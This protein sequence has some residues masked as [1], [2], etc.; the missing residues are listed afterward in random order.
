LTI[1]DLPLEFRPRKTAPTVVLL[2]VIALEVAFA[3]RFVLV[4]HLTARTMAST[5]LAFAL[6]FL[7]L[8]GACVW[9]IIR[10]QTRTDRLR[11][12]ETGVVADLNGVERR[13]AWGEMARLHIVKM[14]ARSGLQLVA[15]ERQ[16]EIDFDARASVIWPRFGPSTPQFLGLLRAGRARW[17]AP[18]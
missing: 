15:I 16:G 4:S 12:D 7:A 18:G 9:Q 3:A 8:V 14:H 11:I 6:P 1:D 13:W 17:G 10:I 5:G 2:L